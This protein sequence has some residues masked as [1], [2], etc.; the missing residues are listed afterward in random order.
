M[1]AVVVAVALTGVWL[2][3][4]AVLLVGGAGLAYKGSVW[5]RWSLPDFM[6]RAFGAVLF[7]FGVALLSW[8]GTLP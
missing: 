6:V 1:N 7:L 5:P 8:P 4:C 3:I 2:V